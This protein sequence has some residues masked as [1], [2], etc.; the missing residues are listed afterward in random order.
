MINL[1]ERSRQRSHSQ[2]NVTIALF[3]GNEQDIDYSFLDCENCENLSPTEVAGNTKST[4]NNKRRSTRFKLRA[5][6]DKYSKFAQT[7]AQHTNTRTMLVPAH[8]LNVQPPHIY[9][10]P[11]TSHIRLINLN[12]PSSHI[13]TI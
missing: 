13:K 3:Q 12:P 9:W 5:C 4:N 11:P 10:F 1:D 6:D 7:S 8:V 2:R